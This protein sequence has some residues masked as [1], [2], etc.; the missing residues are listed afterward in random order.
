VS[1]LS[2]SAQSALIEQAERELLPL[3]AEQM[4]RRLSL[5]QEAHARGGFLN[6]AIE[7]LVIRAMQEGRDSAR[8]PATTERS[9]Q[10][11]YE[12]QIRAGARLAF[13]DPEGM[14]NTVNAFALA[15]G[16]AEIAA[17]TTGQAV[18]I[19]VDERKPRVGDSVLLSNGH[20]IV[21]AGWLGRHDIWKTFVDGEAADF[22]VTH[23][24]PFPL[25]PSLAVIDEADAATGDHP[26]RL[27][28]GG[29]P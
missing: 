2:A 15:D 7:W 14:R 29:L 6:N 28:N 5:L 16:V 18:W 11:I 21:E 17:A 26:R 24:Y 9:Q 1:A 4:K 25:A 13:L 22:P 10:T 20:S 27:P 19:S 8:A 3:T 12:H 23:W